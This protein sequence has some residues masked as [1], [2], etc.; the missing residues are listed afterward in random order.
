MKIAAKQLHCNRQQN[1]A[2]HF[3]ENINASYTKDFFQPMHVLKNK[4]NKHKVYENSY[5]D[6]LHL[7]ELCTDREQRG[8]SSRSRNERKSN[9]HNTG[10]GR[11]IVLVKTNAEYHLQRKKK[12]DERARNSKITHGDAD[13]MKN[14]LAHKKKN[15][16]DNSGNEGCLAAVYLSYLIFDIN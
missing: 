16:H 7:S 9:G 13:K 14:A 12:Q 10:R 11:R 15:D 3:P 6:V 1:N 8:K 2:K 4:I 5:N